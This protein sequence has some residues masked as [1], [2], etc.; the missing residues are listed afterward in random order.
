LTGTVGLQ[1]ARNLRPVMSNP[2]PA[3]VIPA[4]RCSF[5]HGFH[6]V[7]RLREL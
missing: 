1:K 5:R 7:L 2:W 4:A 6:V 3:D